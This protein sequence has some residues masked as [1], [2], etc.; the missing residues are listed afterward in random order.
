MAQLLETEISRHKERAEHGIFEPNLA[1]SAEGEGNKRLNNSLQQSEENSLVFFHEINHNYDS[2]L[3]QL[4]PT[5]GKVRLGYTVSDLH[6]NITNGFSFIPGLNLA[7]GSQ[8]ET[9]VGITVTQPLLKSAGISV[10]MANIRLAAMDSDIA[11]QLYRRQLMLAI[12]Q[13][14]AAY[15]NLYFAQEQLRFFQESVAVAQSV[16]DDSRER[17]KTGRAS[18]LDVLESESALA[19]R[20]AKQNEARQDYDDATGKL[21]TLCAAVPRENGPTVRAVDRPSDAKVVPSYSQSFGQ[22][23]DANPE[24]L[25]QK[26]RLDQERVRLGVARNQ[27]LPELD[28]KGSFGY[29]GLGAT[30]G[31][32]MDY[33]TSQQYPSWSLGLE[34]NIPLAANIKGRHELSAA[35]LSLQ[36]AAVNLKS[37]Q[38]QIANAI[39]MAISKSRTWQE[40]IQ[41]Y[42][43]VVGFNESLLKTEMARLN[44]GRVEPRKVLEVEADLLEARQ[45]LA[46]ALVR[47]QRTL[48]EL[49]MA[50]GSLLRERHL[51]LTREELRHRTLSRIKSGNIP[52]DGFTPVPDLPVTTLN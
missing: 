29:N 40:S 18:E 28:V 32:S 8:Y 7:M 19:L 2:A 50:D 44:V 9:F 26:V 35:H 1:L 30:L 16:L 20:K 6:N 33:L 45:S 25:A 13:A 15:W 47:Y 41:S 23:F 36:E 52:A 3:E 42:Q 22:A 5:G 14:E 24:Y 38:T 12:S 31:Q 17:L 48:L 37:V 4:M 46:D 11:F 21:M 10:T 39:Q 43:T 51:E 34:L 49:K 27:A